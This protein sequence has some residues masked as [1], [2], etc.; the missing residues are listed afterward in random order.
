M[1]IK[2]SNLFSYFEELL[3]PSFFVGLHGISD[4]P[5]FKNEYS[6]LSKE[7]KA[8]NI[9]SMGLINSR[10]KSIKS[11]CRIFGRLSET[12]K[13]NKRL[14][15]DFNKYRAYN[16]NG[17]QYIVVVAVPVVFFP[18]DGR[19]LFTGWMDCDVSYNDDFSPFECITDKLCKNCIPK[20]F[21]LGYYSYDENDDY[22]DF[23][24]NNGYYTELSLSLKDKFISDFFSSNGIFIDLMKGTDHCKRLLD[25]SR[26]RGFY[27]GESFDLAGNL[28]RQ[29]NTNFV[30]D[31]KL[32]F[33]DNF[34]YSI[35][36]FY[37]ISIDAIDLDRVKPSF[38]MIFD[39][40]YGNYMKEIVINKKYNGR[41]LCDVVGFYHSNEEDIN[42][43]VSV[44]DFED[45]IRHC[46]NTPDKVYEQYYQMNYK[47][48]NK[49]FIDYIK[50]LKVRGL[51]L[52]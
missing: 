29:L 21:I 16:S 37:S 23:T 34:C 12:Y 48:I 20:E 8:K 35:K 7:E 4:N 26:N 49:E 15:L 10:H 28:L 24:F 46:G 44:E 5:D 42:S 51:G 6:D 41:S 2:K 52:K 40:I 11:T 14:I 18:S 38:E 22:V 33:D 9:V 13:K 3:G 36:S 27:A 1:K 39:G 50:N 17:K 31:D 43:F 19:A 30:G 45:W 47:D 25:E 32:N